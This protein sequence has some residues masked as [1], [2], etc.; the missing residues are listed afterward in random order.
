[1]DGRRT[2]RRRVS[3]LVEALTV[4][5]AV[6]SGTAAGVFLAF[7][8]LVMPALSGL[9]AAEGIAAMQSINKIAV[10]PVFM[11][12]LFGTAAGCVPVLIAG[13]R[14][15]GEAAGALG[16]AGSALFLLGAVGVTAVRNVPLNDALAAVDP[17]GRGAAR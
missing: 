7:S 11:T 15:W 5:A 10:R 9:P 17:Q 13:V 3:P 2:W 8:R 6:G 16:T 12:V 4:G 14:S 1:M